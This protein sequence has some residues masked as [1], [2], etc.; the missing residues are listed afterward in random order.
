MLIVLWFLSVLRSVH[1]GN[2]Y[3]PQGNRG[4]GKYTAFVIVFQLAIAWVVTFIIFQVGRILRDI[5]NEMVQQFSAQVPSLENGVRRYRGY[6]D[7]VTAFLLP[8]IQASPVFTAV[9]GFIAGILLGIF[10]SV[11]GDRIA[12]RT[13]HNT[14]HRHCPLQQSPFPL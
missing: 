11:S 5:L 3:D 7:H 9:I 6:H 12:L 10:L 14:C 13:G 8:G 1:R 2:G 4:A